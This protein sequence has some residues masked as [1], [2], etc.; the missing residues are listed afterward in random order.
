M[1]IHISPQ[2]CPDQGLLADHA[3]C[4]FPNSE[5][6]IKNINIVTVDGCGP[7]NQ[8][9]SMVKMINTKGN[10]F[11]YQ[12]VKLYP[13]IEAS[14]EA[15]TYQMF[16][17]VCLKE[18][19]DMKLKTWWDEMLGMVKELATAMPDLGPESLRMTLDED[20]RRRCGVEKER[21]DRHDVFMTCGK[22]GEV[23]MKPHVC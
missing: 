7:S 18:K 21:W 11:P 4:L 15:L 6:V 20:M 3:A 5:E 23:V 17:R 1:L 13:S 10:R 9:F 16:L 22:C 2:I 12:N 19:R 8:F 14:L